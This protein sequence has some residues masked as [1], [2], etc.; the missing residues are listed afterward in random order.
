MPTLRKVAYWLCRA[1]TRFYPVLID[2]WGDDPD[3][4]LAVDGLYLA[5][6][7]FIYRTDKLLPKGT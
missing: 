5:C 4:V 6:R 2:T 3:F 1:L 7:E